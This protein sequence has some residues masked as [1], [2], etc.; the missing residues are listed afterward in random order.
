MGYRIEQ[1]IILISALEEVVPKFRL[2]E[3]VRISQVSENQPGHGGR[4]EKDVQGCSRHK[5]V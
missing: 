1:G 4:E 3:P 5:I 2:K